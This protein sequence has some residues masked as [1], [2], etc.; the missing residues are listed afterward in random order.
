MRQEIKRG[1][2]T[3]AVNPRFEVIPYNP[4]GL[5]GKPVIYKIRKNNPDYSKGGRE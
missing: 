3:K 4:N 5:H 2:K 1:R